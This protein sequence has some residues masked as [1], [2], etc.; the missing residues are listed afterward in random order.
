LLSESLQDYLE[1]VTFLVQRDRVAR[2]KEIAAMVG[3]GKSSATGAVRALAERG[4]VHYG[5]YQFVT[6]TED[7]EAAGRELVGRHRVLKRFLMDV[8]GVPER[9]AE[10]VGCKMEHA[11]KG[12]V[13]DRFVQFLEFLDQGPARG[14]RWADT[15][16]H[17]RARRGRSAA[18]RRRRRKTRP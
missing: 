3:V 7:G 14:G 12:E 17:F 9:E 18:P 2:M 10:A 15:F 8:L 1:A 13:L 11:I 16:R 5:P 4:L 6:L